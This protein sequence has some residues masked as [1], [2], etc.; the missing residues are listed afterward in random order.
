[1]G[2]VLLRSCRPNH[3]APPTSTPRN[4]NPVLAAQHVVVLRQNVAVWVEALAQGAQVAA[5]HLLVVRF[6]LGDG[7]TGTNVS[8]VHT[9]RGS[10]AV[11]ANITLAQP[12]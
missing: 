6:L 9:A 5:Q 8:A 7:Q 12:Q 2:E 10:T 11:D 3:A 1:M 4:S